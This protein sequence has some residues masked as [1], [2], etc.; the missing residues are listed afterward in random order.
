MRKHLLERLA[1][2][3]PIDLHRRARHVALNVIGEDDSDH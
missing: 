3:V 2:R 1:H